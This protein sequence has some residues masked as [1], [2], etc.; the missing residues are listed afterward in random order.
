[1]NTYCSFP[2]WLLTD[3]TVFLRCDANVPLKN[4]TIIDDFRLQELLPTIDLLLEKKARIILATHIGRPNGF[5][6]TVSTRHLMPWFA[7][8]GYHIVYAADAQ[9]AHQLRLEHGT[10]TIILLENLRFF[11]GE[12]TDD[13]AWAQQLH[14][15]ATYYV[16]D[17]FASLHRNDVSIA[18]LPDYYQAT[19]KSFGLLVQQEIKHLAPLIG[20]PPRPFLVL[21]GGGKVSDK[22]PLIAAMITHADSVA[23]LPALSFTFM[24][25]AHKSVGTSRVDTAA[26]PMIHTLLSH[27]HKKLLLPTDYLIEAHGHMHYCAAGDIPADAN[28]ISCGPETVAVL[29]TYIDAAGAIFFNGAPGFYE[30]PET[31]HETNALLKHIAESAAYSVIGGGDTIAAASKL[32]LLEQFS[33]VSSGGGATLAML[34]GTTLPGYVAMQSDKNLVSVVR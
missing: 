16:N 22:L 10:D 21:V 8:H 18:L 6:E 23:I 17:A 14:A 27:A 28:G 19:H 31:R 25:D 12:R 15:L 33:F 29:K 13:R 32:G 7:K 20:M 1:M 9:Q 4:G 34:A 2:G 26:L 11:P 5:D 30:R 24:Y 3:Q